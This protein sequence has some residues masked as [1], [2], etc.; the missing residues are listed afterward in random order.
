MALR[1]SLECFDS[2][3]AIILILRK[4]FVEDPVC[5][6]CMYV[7][8]AY[9]ESSLNKFRDVSCLGTT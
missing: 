8:I 3:M 1:L 4:I 7:C 2:D 6:R 9:L 5:I